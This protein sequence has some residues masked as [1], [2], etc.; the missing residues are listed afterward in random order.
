MIKLIKKKVS[1]FILAIT[2][3]I[4]FL[5]PQSVSLAVD[6]GDNSDDY[7]HVSGNKVLDSNG[8]QVRLTGIAW[9]GFETPNECYH[10]IWSQKMEFILDTAADNGFN[11]LRVPLSVQLVNEWRKGSYPETSAVNAFY[12]PNLEGLNTIEILDASIA[13]CKKI[14]LKVML[15][16]HRTVFSNQTG[17]W[18]GSSYTPEDFEACWKWLAEH[19]KND[20][21][22]IAMD[23]FNEPYGKPTASEGAKWDGSTD[24]TNWK[25]EAEKVGKAILDINPK[26][27]IVVEGVETYPKEGYTY[28]NKDEH[29]Y[30]YT[31]W[32]GNLRG[33]ADFPVN[34]GSYQSQ[35]I[36][37]PHDYGPS[38]WLQSWFQGDFNKDT[39][40][41][42]VW[43][44]NWFY[45]H[46][47]NTAPILIG[48][49]GGKMDDGINEKWMTALTELIEDKEI[50]HTFWCLNS[51]S[52]DTGGIFM[53]NDFNDVDTEKLALIQRSLWKDSSGKFVGLDHKIN[54]GKNGTHVSS[55]ITKKA[56]ILTPIYPTGQTGFDI[57]QPNATVQVKLTDSSGVV[58]A[59][60]T[61]QWKAQSGSLYGLTV[62]PAIV[63]TDSNGVATTKVLVMLPTG[64]TNKVITVDSYLSASFNND[65]E[66]EAST[67]NAKVYGEFIMNYKNGDVNMDGYVDAI[68]FALLKKYLFDTGTAIDK[69]AADMNNDGNIDALDAALLKK[70]LLGL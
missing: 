46:E 6:L 49:W 38:V 69:L 35:L 31:W 24:K 63:T 50:N 27:L 2:L 57:T 33:V 48:E 17:L 1:V 36:Y 18:Y 58:L 15:D 25:Y 54:L 52:A 56:T 61:V 39:L 44:S 70:A 23:L 37:S 10:G 47:N 64:T 68:D 19:Y 30:Y 4:S 59:G 65:T 40:L 12:N 9:F 20:D 66:Y 26:L 60:K 11:L 41:R 7:L 62:N 5:L 55:G 16:M 67:C 21:T 13:Y 51:N 28:A 14:G 29:N 32:G 43:N 34:L 8:K 42:D 53:G 22:V 3:M 45:I